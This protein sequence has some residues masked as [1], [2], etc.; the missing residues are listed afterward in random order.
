M[1]KTDKQKNNT[2]LLRKTL[3]LTGI[4]HCGKTTQ[5]RLL[6]SHF[7]CKFFDTD[8]LVTSMTG[9]TPR[10]IYTS[11]GKESFMRAEAEACRSLLGESGIFVVSTG[12]GICNNSEAIA[13]LKKIGT[14][15]FLNSDETTA[16]DRIIKE[17]KVLDDGSLT[18]LPAYIAKENPKTIDDVRKSFHN[19]YEE[20][21]Q[22]YKSICDVEVEM[23][24]LSKAENMQRIID[25]VC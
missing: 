2:V 11:D 21:Q 24:Q 17:V 1:K 3:V 12:G 13:H 5:G 9:K 18:N 16:C 23:M 22:I 6:S 15:V 14:I 25:S 4:K 10:E 8:D 19:F 7:G 20:R